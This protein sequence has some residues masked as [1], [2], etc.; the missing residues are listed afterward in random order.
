MVKLLK[1]NS[2]VEPQRQHSCHVANECIVG[3]S[4]VF[5]YLAVLVFP[6]ER[7]FYHEA[8]QL[9]S[10][11]LKQPK[12]TKVPRPI[13]TASAPRAIAR[14]NSFYLNLHYCDS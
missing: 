2:E 10:N 9:F 7:S 5:L 12:A 11:S 14:S 8:K 1:P 6:S 3:S 4:E 13:D